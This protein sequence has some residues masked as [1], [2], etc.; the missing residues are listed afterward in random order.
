M[1]MS[2]SLSIEFQILRLDNIKIKV[3][4]TKKKNLRMRIG[5]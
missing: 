1:W 4:N 2:C 3:N 5:D